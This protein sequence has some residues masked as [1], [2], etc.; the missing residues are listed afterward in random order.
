V[1]EAQEF[2]A[3]HIPGAINIPYAE[4]EGRMDEIAHDK[5]QVFYCIHS[6]WRGPY[7][8]NLL[9]DNGFDN[10]YVLE[11]GLSG[12]NAGGTV[13]YPSASAEIPIAP[14]PKDLAKDLKHPETRAYT[15]K[16]DL[17]PD[18][19]KE[20]DGQNGRP[21]YVAANGIIYDVTAS[22]LWR[23]GGHDP[24]HGDG[25]AGRDLSELLIKAPH[26]IE[27]LERFPVVGKLI[28]E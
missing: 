17:T 2:E 9:L 6:S 25:I 21:A 11:G 10:A 24:A 13:V 7:V 5:P 3:G 20:F 18:Q 19:L 27:N 23:G 28:K 1:R 16:I 22:R 26:G 14:Y 12:W 4:V 15:V 8:A